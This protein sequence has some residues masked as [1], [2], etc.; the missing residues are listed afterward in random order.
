MKISDNCKIVQAATVTAGASG[1]TAITSSAVDMA[2]FETCCFIV[3]VGGITGT[4][5]TSIKVQQCDTTGGSYADLLGTSVTIADTDD[6]KTFYVE[7]TRPQEQFLKLVVSRATAA[8]TV[9]GVIAILGG[10]RKL[11]TSHGTSVSGE[12]HYGIAEGTA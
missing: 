11:P 7:V 10:A 2:G 9:G 1:T 8:A 12:A 6:D 5:V 4:A 3:P